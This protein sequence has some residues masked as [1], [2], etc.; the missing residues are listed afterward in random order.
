MNKVPLPHYLL[1]RTDKKRIL[2]LALILFSGWYSFQPF[3]LFLI[4]SVQTLG[5]ARTSALPRMPSPKAAMSLR[6]YWLFLVTHHLVVGLTLSL[7][8]QKLHK[9]KMRSLAQK[10][11]DENQVCV[12]G[13]TRAANADLISTLKVNHAA[14]GRT[15]LW[16]CTVYKIQKASELIQNEQWLLQ[17]P[18]MLRFSTIYFPSFT[19]RYHKIFSQTPPWSL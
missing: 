13:L 19:Q 11:G 8:W 12:V 2:L 14:C 1:T 7:W 10:S 5:S 16:G 3:K 9:E 4:N 17:D 6:L 18:D 15:S